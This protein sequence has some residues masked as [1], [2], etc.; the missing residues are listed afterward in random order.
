V[1]ALTLLAT[2]HAAGVYAAG[3]AEVKLACLRCC[4]WAALPIPV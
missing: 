2:E 4:F 1:I 3:L